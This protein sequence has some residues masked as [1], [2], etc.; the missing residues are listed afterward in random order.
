MAP[1]GILGGLKRGVVGLRD[2]EEV[3]LALS[4]GSGN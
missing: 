3:L 1:R 2:W 4:L